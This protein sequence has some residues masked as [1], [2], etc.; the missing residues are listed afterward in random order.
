MIREE[1]TWSVKV[2]PKTDS[3]AIYIASDDF[4]HDVMLRVGGDFVDLNQKK[5]Y[6]EEIAKRL[7]YYNHLLFQEQ[8]V[9]EAV[10]WPGTEER[11][12]IIGSNG[13]LGLHYEKE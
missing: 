11:I 13:A 6:A 2:Y 5:A 9:A 4:H 7:N 10:N 8:S 3:N 1:G 12:D